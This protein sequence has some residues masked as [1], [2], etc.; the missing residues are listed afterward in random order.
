MTQSLFSAYIHSDF[1]GKMIFFSLGV[2]S[3]VTWS[4]LVARGKLLYK[5]RSFTQEAEHFLSK[6]EKPLLPLDQISLQK[7]RNNPFYE[8]YSLLYIHALEYLEKNQ[9]YLQKNAEPEEL[10]LS[11][12]DIDALIFHFDEWMAQKR[13]DWK[14]Y[15]STLSMI[16]SLAPFLG[17]LGTVWGIFIAFSRMQ[18]TGNMQGEEMLQG[19]AMA[20]AT[21]ILGLLITIPSLIG[22]VCIQTLLQKIQTILQKFSMEL[23]CRVEKMYR[24]VDL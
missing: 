14:E 12:D 17:L 21:T 4:I 1:F 13:S 7:S 6:Q 22:Y 5:M 19:I 15:L 2:L 9:R 16:T 10:L 18:M 3:I 20:L 8:C 23:I 11:K 24:K